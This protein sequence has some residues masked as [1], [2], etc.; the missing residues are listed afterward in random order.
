MLNDSEA[1]NNYGVL[2]QEI[3]GAK[4]SDL[5]KGAKFLRLS[6]EHG[7]IYGMSNYAI[8]LLNG[9]GVGKKKKKQSNIYENQQILDIH[10]LNYIME[11]CY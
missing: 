1:Q 3:E 4:E 6:A 9:D 7:N 5:I 11:T 2:S 8:A 10:M